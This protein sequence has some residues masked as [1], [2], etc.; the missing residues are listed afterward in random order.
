MLSTYAKYVT[1]IKCTVYLCEEIFRYIRK[2][3]HNNHIISCCCCVIIIMIAFIRA[4]SD[5]LKSKT[6]LYIGNAKVVF[7]CVIFIS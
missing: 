7:V 4:H 1:L 5:K 3:P 2:V 6:K